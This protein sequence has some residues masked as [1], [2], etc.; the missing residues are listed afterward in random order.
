MKKLMMIII[1]TLLSLSLYAG[2][3]VI[4]LTMRTEVCASVA[5][6]TGENDLKLRSN[7]PAYS[8]RYTLKNGCVTASSSYIAKLSD[9]LV[10]SVSSV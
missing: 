8:V 7:T 10:I 9:I 6:I 5:V 1:V 4:T 2:T 3:E